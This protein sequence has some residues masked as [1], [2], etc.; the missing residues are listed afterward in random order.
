MVLNINV[1]LQDV[2]FYSG[3]IIILTIQ[4]YEQ[5]TNNQQITNKCGVN[6]EF[7]RRIALAD[8]QHLS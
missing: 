1:N 2:A 6:H 5:Q 7:L 8:P 4:N 3:V